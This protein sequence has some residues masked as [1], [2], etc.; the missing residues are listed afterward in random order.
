MVSVKNKK[1]TGS[2]AANH[3][4][5]SLGFGIQQNELGK[6]IW[7][8]GDNGDFKCFF[9]TIPGKKES[10][11]YFTNSANGLDVTQ[12]LLDHYFGKQSWWALQWL[13]AAF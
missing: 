3:I 11:V 4:F 8:W 10:I 5:W 9:M 1:T 13:D 7:H 12:K 6:S 2:E